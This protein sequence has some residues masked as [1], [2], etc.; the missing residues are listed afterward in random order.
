MER[1]TGKRKALCLALAL[2]LSLELTA[3]G[4][5]V[6]EE[7]VPTQRETEATQP[8][9]APVAA[10]DGNPE[11]V[12]C[13]SSYTAEEIDRSAVVAEM[14]DVAL[15]N[16]ELQ[17]RYYLAVNAYRAAGIQPSPDFTRKLD[18]QECPLEDGLS[19]QH[20]F[21]KT[22][23]E[24]WRSQ[25]GLIL[26]SRE[27]QTVSSKYYAP[28]ESYHDQFFSDPDLP[29][30]KFI[31]GNK[32][33]YTPNRRHQTF[34]DDLP[35]TLE[36]L[37]REK[38]YDSADALAKAFAGAGQE[39][40]LAAAW[41]LNMSYFYYTECSY[42]FAPEA[43]SPEESP[44]RTA[45]LRHLLL[46][47]E[48]TV[49]ADG[50]VAATQESWEKCR[51]EAE[52]LLAAWKKNFLTQRNAEGSFAELVYQNA[53]DASSRLTGGL[54]TSVRPG[55]LVDAVDDWC[56]AGDRQPGDTA[57]LESDLGVHLVFF[58]GSGSEAT[59]EAEHAQRFHEGRALVEEAR[60][61]A[62][63]RVDYSLAA[64]GEGDGSVSAE[65]LLYPDVAH[66]RFPEVM[67]YL[68]Q[69]FPLAPFGKGARLEIH[70]CG[71]TSLAMLATYM[72]DT[73]YTPDAL[74]EKYSIYG[75]TSG[76]DGQIFFN[77]P[78]EFGFFLQKHTTKWEEVEAALKNG[79][80]VV[81]LQV[82][83]YFTK[84]GHYILLAGM[85]E[86]GTVI[87]RDPN[88]RAY[89][90]LK[91]NKVDAFT[92][93]QVCRGAAGYYI[94]EKKVTEIPDCQRCGSGD[95]S[96]ALTG[97]YLCERCR[98]ALIRRNDFLAICAGI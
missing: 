90:N 51:V 79:Q 53:Q 39:D 35:E 19:W 38:G 45:D 13:R 92:P 8:P 67:L 63:V 7:T 36:A 74:A 82:K 60:N 78:Q 17:V 26:K 41:G 75:G 23:I 86:D 30:Q 66:E 18:C 94:F 69:D 47:P 44:E 62:P 70:G 93:E 48:G 59:Q 34:L 97:P 73:V 76:T 50:K 11:S 25:T 58:R 2:L 40:L 33:R 57:V 80:L 31:Y 72:T 32:V 27:E 77:V 61:I 16:G 46:R 96:P 84:S 28:V 55:Q 87:V 43:Q 88:I 20:F 29:A 10:A 22:A 9:Q 12:L 24:Q 68:Q 65:E 42:G 14:D 91:E 3:C 85:R 64:L 1:K 89:G 37:A 56:F 81:S 98:E 52:R 49:A 54:Y 71:I 6:R 21:L 83:G 15:T 4:R 95:Y 5:P